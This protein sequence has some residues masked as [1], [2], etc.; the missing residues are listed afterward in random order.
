[1]RYILC[2]LSFEFFLLFFLTDT[3]L[4]EAIGRNPGYLKLRKIRAAQNISR[5]VG[6]MLKISVVEK[7][8]IANSQNKVY[9][10]GNSL[11]LNISDKEFDDQS[12]KLKSKSDYESIPSKE[13]NTIL[14]LS[15]FAADR[16]SPK[17][18]H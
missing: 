5:T 7:Y 9:L 8:L 16:V 4:G 18:F 3:Y 11:M 17:N 13:G 1:M 15:Q 6:Q 10:S 2:P 12:E 14:T